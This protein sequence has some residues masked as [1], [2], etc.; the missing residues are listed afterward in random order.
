VKIGD[1]ADFAPKGASAETGTAEAM[2]EDLIAE[3]ESA[4]RNMRKAA[5]DADEG[6][7]L[8]TTDML[9]D[10]LSFHEKAIWMLNATIGA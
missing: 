3:H 5:I 4:T 8:V 1:A 6:D 7:D 9:T 2:V 10:R